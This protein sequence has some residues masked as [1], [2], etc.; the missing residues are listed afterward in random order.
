MDVNRKMSRRGFVALTGAASLSALLAACGGG[1]DTAAPA[2]PRAGRAGRARS[3]RARTRGAGAR[4]AARRAGGGACPGRRSDVRPGLRAGRHDRALRVG[5]L[6]RHLAMDV[7]DVHGRRV[8]ED[9]PAQVHV[10]RAGHPGAR[11]GGIR[12]QPGSR[13]SLHRVLAGLPGCGPDPALR[14]GAAARLRGNPGSDPRG[15][16]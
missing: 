12:L 14:Q 2:A 7:A 9:E 13:S 4:R 10:P 16:A 5:R 6:R 1:E 15:E 8:R 11:Q 3:G